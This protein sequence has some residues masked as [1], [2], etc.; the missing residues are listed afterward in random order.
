M[1]LK[2]ILGPLKAI[3]L[4]EISHRLGM[5]PVTPLDRL[6]LRTPFL[7]DWI[8]DRTVGRVQVQVQVIKMPSV[9]EMPSTTTGEIKMFSTTVDP[10]G[11]ITDLA[12]CTREET[13]YL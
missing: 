4:A 6:P 7:G 5:D 8:V 2:I 13:R 10:S 12:I 11:K 9:T 1:N 3:D